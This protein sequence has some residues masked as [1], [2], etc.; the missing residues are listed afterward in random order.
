[1]KT[2]DRQKNYVSKKGLVDQSVLRATLASIERGKEPCGFADRVGWQPWYLEK[3]N[4][5]FDYKGTAIMFSY[6]LDTKSPKKEIK[7]VIAGPHSKVL[8]NTLDYYL[9]GKEKK[10]LLKW[11]YDQRWGGRMALIEKRP[12][13]RITKTA[14]ELLEGELIG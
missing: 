3:V 5:T 2:I 6:E 9:T 14:Y 12:K 11:K 1:M 13:K 10:P 8:E 4:E 7:Y